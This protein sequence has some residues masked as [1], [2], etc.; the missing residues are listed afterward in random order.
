MQ[1][2]IC[3][4]QVFLCSQSFLFL[5]PHTL[6]LWNILAHLIAPVDCLEVAVSLWPIQ[7]KATLCSGW[8]VL[9]SSVFSLHSR[10]TS[11]ERSLAA[12]THPL[13]ETE[14][15]SPTQTLGSE[16]TQKR[17]FKHHHLDPEEPLHVLLSFFW[18]SAIRLLLFYACANTFSIQEIK[19]FRKVA[20]SPLWWK[21]ALLREKDWTQSMPISHISQFFKCLPLWI[22]PQIL[23]CC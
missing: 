12:S 20:Q 10:Q 23:V 7:F 19:V 13:Q 16:L 1:I 21:V 15:P 2:S 17:V 22:Q 8:S 11:I 3:P 14:L 9:V 6:P 18:V 4:A 5:L